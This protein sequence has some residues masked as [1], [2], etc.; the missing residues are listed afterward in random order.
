MVSAMILPFNNSIMGA[1]FQQSEGMREAG[2]WQGAC[3]LADFLRRVAV[4]KQN[5]PTPHLP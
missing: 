3:S 1:T 5:W 2:D 4:I